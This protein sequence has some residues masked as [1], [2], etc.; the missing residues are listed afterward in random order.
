MRRE[1]RRRKM[2]I[3]GKDEVL[4]GNRVGLANAIALHLEDFAE[5]LDVSKVW[6]A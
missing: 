6:T 4:T 5:H 1:L 3:R 2:T